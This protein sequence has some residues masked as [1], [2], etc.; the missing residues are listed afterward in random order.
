ML[1]FRPTETRHLHAATLPDA[2][3]TIEHPK[4]DARTTTHHPRHRHP[5][6]I[7]D[8]TTSALHRNGTNDYVIARNIK[9]ESR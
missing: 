5:A 7:P 6:R 1:V 9:N 2:N 3:A 8:A 4:K